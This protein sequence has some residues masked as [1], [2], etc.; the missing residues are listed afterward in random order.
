MRPS[1]PIT[2]SN[3][4]AVA[5]ITGSNY[6]AAG[7]LTSMRPQLSTTGSNHVAAGALTPMR[8]SMSTVSNHLA[9]ADITGSNYVTKAK[10]PCTTAI[11]H[12][13]PPPVPIAVPASLPAPRNQS[14][15]KT[16]ALVILLGLS[17]QLIS[18]HTALHYEG[19]TLLVT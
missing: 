17:R 11:P 13:P 7:A 16:T 3:Y 18:L 19:P 8:P 10:A 12:Q 1:L 5:D 14:P 6:V 2:G 15:L 4:F 9:A